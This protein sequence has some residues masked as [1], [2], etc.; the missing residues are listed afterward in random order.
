MESL[1][2]DTSEYLR[3]YS[4]ELGARILAQFPALHQPGDQVHPGVA[5]LR[6]KPFPAQTLAIMG[7]VRQW[8]RSNAAAATLCFHF[9]LAANLCFTHRNRRGTWLLSLNVFSPTSGH[10]V[11]PNVA[12]LR[13]K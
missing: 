3:L 10:F 9:V 7:I 2:T 12:T 1:P 6:R 4:D 13:F 8:E 11:L 5:R